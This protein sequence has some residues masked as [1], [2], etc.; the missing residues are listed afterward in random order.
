M[1]P[2]PTTMESHT[3]ALPGSILNTERTERDLRRQLSR[4]SRWLYRLGFVNLMPA[5]LEA[6][7]SYATVGEIAAAMREVFWGIPGIGRH[8]RTASKLL[9]RDRLT[10]NPCQKAILE[11]S[12]L[13]LPSNGFWRNLA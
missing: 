13:I 2:K 5:I 6:V 4:F 10:K 8:L 3:S 12:I 1:T 7:E 9:K 11:L